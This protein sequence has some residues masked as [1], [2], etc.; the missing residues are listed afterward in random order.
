MAARNVQHIQHLSSCLYLQ[1]VGRVQGPPVLLLYCPVRAEQ[2]GLPPQA[3]TAQMATSTSDSQHPVLIS[4][5]VVPTGLDKTRK[6]R[7][8]GCGVVFLPNKTRGATRHT[9]DTEADGH[10]SMA[11]WTQ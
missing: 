9:D 6:R 7:C 11:T 10:C 4:C 5:A 3:D 1:Y 2:I 8:R